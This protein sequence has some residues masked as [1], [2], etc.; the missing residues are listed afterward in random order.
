MKVSPDTPLDAPNDLAPPES[1]LEPVS[2][3]A[4]VA[5]VASFVGFLDVREHD[6]A[7]QLWDMP[8][9]ILGDTHVHAPMSLERLASWLRDIEDGADTN[10][11]PSY[12]S[13]GGD[14]PPGGSEPL[15]QRLEWLSKRVAMVDVRWPRRA[16]GGLLAGV[17]GTTFLI[18]VDQRGQAKIRGLLLRSAS[19]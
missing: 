2:A 6:R 9:L 14:A 7:A 16:R 15:V 3:S 4:V 8:A 13:A 10:T 5:L 12:G 19:P 1:S 11:P 18:R 17:E